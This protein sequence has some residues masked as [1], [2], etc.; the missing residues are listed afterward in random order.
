[1]DTIVIEHV[2]INELP[3]AWR[4]R[5]V[6]PVPQGTRVRVLIEEEIEEDEKTVMDESDS[7]YGMWRD[8]DDTSNVAAYIRDLRASRFTDR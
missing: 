8:R 6:D 7:A 3:E 4:N 2:G 5:L 1:M